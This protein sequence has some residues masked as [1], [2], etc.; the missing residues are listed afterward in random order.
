[1][2]KNFFLFSSFAQAFSPIMYILGS[3]GGIVDPARKGI[4]EKKT[5]R[6]SPVGQ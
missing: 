4:D 3:P 5:T 6:T 1:M 2:T